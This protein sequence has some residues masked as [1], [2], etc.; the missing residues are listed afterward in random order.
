MLSKIVLVGLF[1]TSLVGGGAA[2]GIT[3]TGVEL[4]AGPIRIESGNGKIVSARFAD[5]SAMSF[6]INLTGEQHIQIKL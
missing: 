2:T 5:Q 1:G 4:A 3:P 6:T